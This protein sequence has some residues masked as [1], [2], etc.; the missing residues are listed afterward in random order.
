MLEEFE[1]SEHQRSASGLLP[2]C[3]AKPLVTRVN[4]G[5]H[6]GALLHPDLALFGSHRH[7]VRTV[8][9]LPGKNARSPIKKP[10]LITCTFLR[11]KFA[12]L[13]LAFLV[14]VALRA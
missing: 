13:S 4:G 10:S 11:E 12:P 9:F 3:G 6:A 5:R 1:R 14:F 2:S 7:E 8:A